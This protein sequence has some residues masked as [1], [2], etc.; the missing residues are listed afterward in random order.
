MGLGRVVGVGWVIFKGIGLGVCWVKNLL[1]LV[2]VF[3]LDPVL[4]F[5]ILRVSEI[6]QGLILQNLKTVG[7]NSENL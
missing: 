1:D 4:R 5:K 7:T 3:L 6:R 2:L